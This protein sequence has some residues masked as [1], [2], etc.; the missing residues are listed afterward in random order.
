VEYKHEINA[1]ST[2]TFREDACNFSTEGVYQAT[3]RL[4]LTGNYAGKL[5]RDEDFS[6]YTDLIAARF[7]EKTIQRIMKSGI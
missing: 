5:F 7:L 4:Q 1:G 2:P 6:S 3:P